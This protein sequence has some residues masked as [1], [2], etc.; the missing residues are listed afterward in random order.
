MAS[1][2][3]TGII[4]LWLEARPFLTPDQIKQF[5]QSNAWTDSF[6]GTV[7]NNTWGWGKIDA[8]KTIKSILNSTTLP[9]PP[10]AP[11][12]NPASH[13]LQTGFFA[14]WN[15]SLTATGYRLDVATNIGFTSFV[16]GYSD[17]D[18]G[19]V[20]T[21]YISGLSANTTYYYRVRAYNTGGPSANSNVITATTLPFPPSAPVA[22]IA[23]NILQTG[24][25]ASWS[26]SS[27][28]TSYWLDV[29]TNVGFTSFVSGFSDKYI[30][31]VATYS[32]TGLSA[33]T[34]YYYR[35]RAYNSGGPSVNSNIIT[36]TTL[37]N[38]P[39]AP[40]ANSASYF[41]QTVFFAN[42]S[43]PAT[44]TGYRLDVATNIGFANFVSGLNDKDVS[45]VT[46]YYIPG[47]SANTTYYYRVRAYNNGG[48]SANSNIISATTLPFPPS[49]P[50][51]NSATNLSQTSFSANWSSSSTAIYYL[52]DV[53]TNIGFT[54]FVSGYTDKYVG[55]VTSNNVT[56][57]TAKTTYYYRVRAYNTGGPSGSSNIITVSTLSNPSS[58]PAGLTASSC[59][60][61]V[62]LTWSKSTG[63]DFLRYRIYG[64]TTNNPTTKIDSTTNGISDISKVIS[65]LKRGNTYNFRVTAVN[66]DGV[67]SGFSNQSAVIVK[68]GVVPKIRAKWGDVLI[69]SNL[70]DSIAG[71][72]WLKSGSIIPN[73]T[74]QYYVTNKQPGAYKVEITDKNGCKNSSNPISISGTKSLS[75]YP[76]PTSLSFALKISD[77]SEGRALVSI[78]NSAGI[79]VMEFQ[80][81]NMNDEI[82][83]EIPVK[84][85]SKGIYIVQVLIDNKD[86]YYTKIVVIK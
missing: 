12:A 35:V 10:S 39:S 73:A 36:A 72:Q 48:T 32:I 30:G 33:N 54:N 17:K 37:Q 81:E 71:F 86:L 8:H 75:V 59:N 5:M 6:T 7:P 43:S 42:W 29:A 61:L 38:P 3:V 66:S 41:L 23:S 50:V 25:S 14:N 34:T 67:E 60:D 44:A 26:G 22:N 64:G 77:E 19:N 57:L 79:K 21:Y 52:L 15:S 49:A 70:G 53:A 58:V 20:T 45:N 28:A 76:N 84:S 46:T 4:A 11:V 18:V 47:L 27:T 31:N 74:T 16:S 40:V 13:F 83:K 55:N 68:S 1:P 63:S 80:V 51:A 56:G 78:I 62:T 2:M 24:F 69:C 82:L 65:G 9:N 85:L